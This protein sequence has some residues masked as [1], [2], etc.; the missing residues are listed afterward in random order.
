M[1]FW[2]LVIFLGIPLF[3]L[4]GLPLITLLG[5]GFFYVLLCI[6]S[7]FIDVI[8]GLIEFVGGYVK[9]NA[10]MFFHSILM[11]AVFTIILLA[12]FFQGLAK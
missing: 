11:M 6:S 12:Y 8:G 7:V 1:L 9:R 2:I 5:V 4:A 10:I 3:V